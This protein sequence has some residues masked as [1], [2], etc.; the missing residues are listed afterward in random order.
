MRGAICGG[1]ITLGRGW[2]S[3][4]KLL[5]LVRR[6][7]SGALGLHGSGLLSARWGPARHGASPEVHS[8]DFEGRTR[9]KHD[10]DGGS[11]DEEDSSRHGFGG[12]PSPL[13]HISLTIRGEG[14]LRRQWEDEAVS[15]PDCSTAFRLPMYPGRRA[16]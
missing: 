3:A 4:G 2:A 10:D 15:L 7:V 16:S 14:Q 13:S 12:G 6:C 9:G 8:V 11:E 1:S 5:H